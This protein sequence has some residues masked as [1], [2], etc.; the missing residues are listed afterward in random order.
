MIVMA[1]FNHET[2]ISSGI[3]RKKCLRIS[4]GCDF[5]ASLQ[6]AMEPLDQ[7]DV[8]S[9]RASEVQIRQTMTLVMPVVCFDHFDALPFT[10][11][12][13][14]QAAKR[15]KEPRLS[16]ADRIGSLNLGSWETLESFGHVL[17]IICS[18]ATSRA[19]TS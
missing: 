19:R 1:S 7:L 6:S 13:Y 15:D 17:W 12:L 2:A 3:L 16:S 10:D 14:F 18:R 4:H 11:G 8:D 9:I 5:M